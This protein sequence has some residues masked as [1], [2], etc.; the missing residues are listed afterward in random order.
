MQEGAGGCRV[1]AKFP[2]GEQNLEKLAET[3]H[4]PAPSVSGGLKDILLPYISNIIYSFLFMT[5]IT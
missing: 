4:P 2:R 3:L 5:S 1:S